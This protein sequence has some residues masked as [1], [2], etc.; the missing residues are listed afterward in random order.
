MRHTKTFLRGVALAAPGLFFLGF[1]PWTAR[2]DEPG[3]FG[4]LFRFGGGASASTAPPTTSPPP[5]P[6]LADTGPPPEIRTAPPSGPLPAE[7][8]V[9]TSPGAQPRLV[10]QPRNYR[11]VT[12]ADP[13]VTRVALGRSNEGSQF[14]MFLQVFADGTVIDSEGVHHVGREG[15]KP[16]IDALKSDELYR[17]R[18]H[19]GGPPTD[20]IEDI[21]VVVYER[22]LG[23]LRANAFSFSG[24]PQGCDPAVR[25]L[26]TVLDGLQSRFSRP[27]S[28]A[29]AGGEVVGAFPQPAAPPV[30]ASVP[31]SAPPIRLNGPDQP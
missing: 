7:P 8:A 4:R 26:Q 25:R 27:A 16:V 22:S 2:G 9:P 11:G 3:L 20:F 14:G 17:L 21:H 19:C 28:V 31:P 5:A 6:G 30:G 29:S 23:R 12:D 10:P 24:N 18:G 13:I 15:V 1:A